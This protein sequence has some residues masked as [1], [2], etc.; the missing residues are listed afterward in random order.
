MESS[1]PHSADMNSADEERY[2]RARMK[3][4]EEIREMAYDASDYVTGPI[5]EKVLAVMAKVPRHRFVPDDA[6]V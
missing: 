2:S 5:S 3:M 1:K 6:A 4:V